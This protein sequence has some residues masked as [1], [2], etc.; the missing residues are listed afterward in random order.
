VERS[1]TDTNLRGQIVRRATQRPG[2]PLAV[3]RETKVGDFDMTVIGEEDIFWFEVTVDDLVCVEVV[4]GHRHFGGI[5]F[6]H[7]V[8]EPLKKKVEG[9]VR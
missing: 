4:E 7:W 6:R 8:R 3:L 9:G 1:G 2:S 5:E